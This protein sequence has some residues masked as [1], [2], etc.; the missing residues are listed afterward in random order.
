MTFM[1][2]TTTKVLLWIYERTN[3]KFFNM[4]SMPNEQAD[5]GIFT[6]RLLMIDVD[7][8]NVNLTSVAT[9]NVSSL[10]D[11]ITQ[12]TCD[13]DGDGLNGK[14]ALLI[15]GMSSSDIHQIHIQYMPV[16]Q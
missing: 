13:G 15:N 8:D 11:R 9:V 12:I 5:V 6:V 7:G 3:Q 16:M 4:D 14:D 10:V 1:C 2:K